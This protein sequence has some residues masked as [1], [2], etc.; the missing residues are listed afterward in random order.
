MAM[1]GYPGA[2]MLGATTQIMNFQNNYSF[3][4]GS[5]PYFV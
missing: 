5:M 1:F 4:S 3:Q 2:G